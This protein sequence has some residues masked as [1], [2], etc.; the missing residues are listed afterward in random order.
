ME[1][2]KARQVE[3]RNQHTHKTNKQT[4]KQTKNNCPTFLFLQHQSLTLHDKILEEE[5]KRYFVRKQE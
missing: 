4:K 3:R 2:E 5:G 1:S